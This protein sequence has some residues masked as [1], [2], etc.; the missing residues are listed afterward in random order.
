[1][2]TNRKFFLFAIILTF[3]LHGNIAGQQA[4]NLPVTSDICGLA[5]PINLQPDSTVIC[6]EDYFINV[7]SIDSVVSEKCFSQFLT[8][9]K[10]QLHI[11]NGKNVPP[12]SV[13]KVWI[14]GAPYSLLLKKSEKLKIPFTFDPQGKTYK[15]VQIMGD[16][17][18]WNPANTVMNFTDEK[19]RAGL[20]LKP[21]NYLYKIV[22]DGKLITDP[23]NPDSADNFIGGFNSVLKIKTLTE[24]PKPEL[25]TME[26]SAHA[27]KIGKENKVSNHLVFWQNFTLPEKMIHNDSAVI[28]IDIPEEAAKMERSFIRVFAYNEAGCSNDLLIPLKYGT[29]I[30]DANIITRSD[31]EAQVIYFVIVD[32]FFDQDTTNNHPLKDRKISPKAN[33]MGGDISGIQKKIEDGYFF[34][35]G[36]NTLWISPLNQ[37]P[38]KGFKEFPPPRRKYSGYHGYWPVSSSRIDYRLGTEP[39]MKELVKTAHENN[40]NVIL[41]YVDNHVHIDHPLWKEHPDWFTSLKLPDGRKN[42]RLFNE[43]RLTTWFDSFLPTFDFSKPEV[44]ET[45]SDSAVYW[46]KTYNLDGFRHDATK[47]VPENYWKRLT[48]KLKTEII[49]PENRSFYQIGETYGSRELIGSYVNSGQ[50]DAQFDFNFYFDL[51]STIINEKEPF[52]KLNTSLL[53][54]FDNYGFHNLMGNVTGNHDLGRF[55]SYADGSLSSTEDDKNAGWTR[56]IVVKDT[57]GYKKL[58]MLTAFIMAIPGVPVI[59]YGDEFGM[60]GAGDPDNRRMMKFDHLTSYEKETRDIAGKLVKLRRSNMSLMYGDFKAVSVAKNTYAFIRTY[61]GDLA[62]VVFNKSNKPE[63]VTVEIPERY[64][65]LKLK[66]HFGSSFRQSGESLEILLEGNTFDLLT[67]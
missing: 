52:E 9:D 2:K 5:T 35:L 53:E 3:L 8:K 12:L 48:Q 41:D 18:G 40:I 46:V 27:I 4:I 51:R 16:Y 10:K 39:E 13:L 64:R 25:F 63:K 44:V 47:H 33:Y 37:N 32:R 65:D 38:E 49:I 28:E 15:T 26:A 7:L 30:R 42:I 61:F 14:G 59:L 62:L 6:L 34:G 36:I 31:K 1:M 50:L 22:V 23:A 21:G 67:N 58:S 60:P 57:I 43:Q 19:W 56:N 45:M 17:N 11:H 20:L 29:V 66:S 54:S 24:E 55:I